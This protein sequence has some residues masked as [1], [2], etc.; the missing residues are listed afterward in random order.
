MAV[1]EEREDSA[2]R[3]AEDSEVG[4]ACEIVSS[5]CKVLTGEGSRKGEGVNEDD[6]R[7]ASFNTKRVQGTV[8]V[9]E[10]STTTNGA[11]TE[12]LHSHP[13]TT[14]LNSVTTQ[15]GIGSMGLDGLSTPPDSRKL[16]IYIA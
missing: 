10:R 7:T 9:P 16:S 15:H 3:S 11:S 12:Y 8:N 6:R 13:W 4:E 1:G 14:N 5:S 2:T